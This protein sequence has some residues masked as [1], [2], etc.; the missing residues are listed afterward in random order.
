MYATNRTPSV[1]PPLL[2]HA[3]RP[4][5]RWRRPAFV[6]RPAN[7]RPSSLAAFQVNAARRPPHDA[8]RG[9]VSVHVVASVNRSDLLSAVSRSSA[10][11][12]LP[13]NLFGGLCSALLRM[14]TEPRHRRTEGAA[15]SAM[16]R[17]DARIAI[18]ALRYPVLNV[19]GT[20]L[21]PRSTAAA[22]DAL[23]LVPRRSKIRGTWYERR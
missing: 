6:R 19:S 4:L 2:L 20:K 15:R 8:F 12:P 5:S 14:G 23:R 16:A 10:A 3:D 1:A 22:P 21:C 18:S 11:K 17:H 13:R 7:G 9:G